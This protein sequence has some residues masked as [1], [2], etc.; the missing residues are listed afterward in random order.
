MLFGTDKDILLFN[1]YVPPI[2]S[3]Y[4]ATVE[5][6]N[7]I[8]NLERCISDML[9]ICGDVAVI[10]CGDFNA[11]TGKYN[12]VSNNLG[13]MTASITDEIRDSDDDIVNG[14]GQNLLSLCIAFDLTILNGLIDRN[15][16]GRFTYVGA[17]GSSVIDYVI[18]SEEI[19]PFCRSLQV[20]ETILSP[21]MRLELVMNCTALWKE[22]DSN[23]RKSVQTKIVWDGQL[24]ETYVNNVWVGLSGSAVNEL[25]DEEIPDVNEATERIMR[26]IEGAADFLKKTFIS[27]SRNKRNWFDGDYFLSRKEVRSKLRKYLH[28]RAEDDRVSYITSRKAYKT[29]IRYKKEQYR[30]RITAVLSDNVKDTQIFWKQIRT[31][32][33]KKVVHTG[34]TSEAWVDHFQE[35]F[36]APVNVSSIGNINSRILDLDA[37]INPESNL[38]DADITVSETMEAIRHLKTGKAPGPDSILGVMIKS[39]CDILLPYL[40]KL[41]NGIFRTSVFPRRWAESIIVPLHKKGS[42]ND[43]NNYRGISL[44]SNLSKVFI[45]ILKSRLQSWADANDIIGEEQAGFRKG[46]ST[47]D[48]V[49][50]LHCVAKRYLVKH[51]KL[52]VAFVDFSKA[53]DT[54]NRQILWSILEQMGITRKMIDM[55]KSI[56]A[57]VKCCVKCDGM[58]SDSFQ[59]LNGLKQGCKLSPL[60]FSLLMTSLVKEIKEKGKHGIQLI[61]NGVDIFVLVFADDIVLLSDTVP[62]LQ[63]Q[64]NSMQAAADRLGLRVNVHKTKVMSFRLGGHMAGH[65]KWYLKGQRLDVVS[66]YK[67]LGVTLSTKLS[68]NILLSDLACRGSA[69]A[70]RIMRT[71]RRIA[72]A[73]PQ[74]L[75]KIVDAQIQPILLY[76]GEIWGI[77]DCHVIESV[78]LS[79]LKQYLNVASRTPNTLVYGETGRY[80]LYINA[81]IK[82]I[83]YWLKILRMGEDRYPHVLYKAMLYNVDECENW[84]SKIKHILARYDLLHIWIAQKVRD[85][86]EFLK[87]L[88][89]RLIEMFTEQWVHDLGKSSRFT[90]YREI[91]NTFG[92]ERY[93]FVLDKKVFRDCMIR[94]RLGVSDLFIHKLRYSAEAYETLCPNCREE[95]E[96]ERHFLLCCPALHDLQEKYLIPHLSRINTDPFVHLIA[97]ND[98]CVI[99]AVATYLYHALRRRKESVESTIRNSFFLD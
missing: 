82:A 79:V 67:Y 31:L 45:H 53:F 13:D 85:E 35:I 47:I 16:S 27:T 48:N 52:F 59:C 58:T 65:E 74:L 33:S 21:H 22:R 64:I 20:T 30:Y 28:T 97:N 7:G 51:K 19:I 38:L 78:H 77:D 72:Y 69:A 17:S 32:S 86:K 68:T 54:V 66:A 84:A 96:D 5:E 93:L 57:S 3:P 62:G 56:Y 95:D 49:F 73:T 9:D 88:K 91:K 89:E 98:T 26:A 87:V 55:L 11:R 80:P 34:I 63:N 81:V 70:S 61:A 42:F 1:V 36:A 41:F 76:G 4:Y 29:L 43:P 94:Y 83:K 60:M 40:K 14:F 71:L 2:G 24:T 75:N 90:L 25:L 12:L 15:K 44:T 10:L 46:Y 92:V 99:R 8:T 18:V 39:A 23:G 6:S 37:S 50:V